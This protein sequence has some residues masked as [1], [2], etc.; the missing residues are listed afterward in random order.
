MGS[1]LIHYEALRKQI[2]VDRRNLLDIQKKKYQPSFQSHYVTYELPEDDMYVPQDAAWQ[3][4]PTIHQFVPIGT[5][6]NK[7]EKPWKYVSLQDL[8]GYI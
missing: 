5:N 3:A 6:S 4:K 7:T 2:I 1:E 8:H